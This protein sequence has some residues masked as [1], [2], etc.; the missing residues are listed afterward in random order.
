MANLFFPQL[1][2][3]A[4]A[5]FPFSKL[6][7]VRNIQNVLADGSVFVT[8]DPGSA[9]IA[10]N[11]SFV[12]LTP[13]DMQVLQAFFS[14][15]SG[16]FAAFTFI[17][18]ADNMLA[19]STDLTNAAWNVSPDLHVT[20]GVSDPF[21]GQSA[22]MLTNTGQTAETISQTVSSPSNYQYCFSIYVRSPVANASAALA[23]T[24]STAR[25]ETTFLCG[26]AWTRMLS[27]GRLN[28][29]G[30]AL[31]SEIK[32]QPGQ[33]LYVFGPQ[34]EPQLEP[35]AYRPT[36]LRCGVYANAHWGSN[37]LWF[38]ADGPDSY[39]TSFSIESAL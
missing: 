4:V 11:L 7:V 34:L 31:T 28:D 2:T 18:P 14:R 6:R 10:W 38:S 33:A 21:G 24:G 32:L 26:T 20:A 35:S 27:Q 12:E 19:F 30:T 17:D 25:A 8:P 1:S 22:F 39:A 29:P 37:Q 5:Q 36:T 9:R 23:R 16:P 13:A 3:G 15:C